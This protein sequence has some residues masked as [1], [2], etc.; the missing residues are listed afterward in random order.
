MQNSA[1]AQSRAT[2]LRAAPPRTKICTRLPR[3]THTSQRRRCISIAWPRLLCAAPLATA[4][5][6]VSTSSAASVADS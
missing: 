6:R 2:P 3:I 1:R 5:P 4:A